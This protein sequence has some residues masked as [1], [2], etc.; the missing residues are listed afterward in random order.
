M[1]KINFLLVCISLLS[2]FIVSCEKDDDKKNNK[3]GEV[4]FSF[5]A[6][7]LLKSTNA[8][9]STVVVSIEDNTGNLVYSSEK[10]E[11]YS[12]NGQYISKPLSLVPGS[13]TLTQYLV[14]D[15]A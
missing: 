15:A 9:A 6:K 8:D 13:Y 7:S 14:L 5:E 1:K 11:L 4:T 3:E 12:F 2:L 10:V